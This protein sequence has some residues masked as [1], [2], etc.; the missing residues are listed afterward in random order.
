MKFLSAC[1]FSA[2]F[3]ASAAVA[4]GSTFTL[5]SYGSAAGTP[6]PAGASNTAVQYEGGL[7]YGSAPVGAGSGLTYDVGSAGVWT[8]AVGGSSWVAQNAGDGPSGGHVEPTGAYFYTTTFVDDSPAESSGLLTVMADDTTGVYLNGVQITAPAGF[9]TAGRCASSAPSCT[10]PTT[11]RLTG[12]VAGTNTLAFDVLQ[13]HG[14]AEGLD[15]AG[16]V[17]TTPEP[18]S[19]LL[20]GTGLSLMAGF[21]NYRRAQA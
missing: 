17:S 1:C 16:T 15:F 20:L 21:A 6:R 19:L 5:A 14:A 18:L 8:P 13:Q 3:A 10:V 7:L 11:F 2:L 9:A 12:F 4:S